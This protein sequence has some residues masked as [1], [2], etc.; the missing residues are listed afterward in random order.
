VSPASPAIGASNGVSYVHALGRHAERVLAP[1]SGI[2]SALVAL[3]KGKRAEDY[4]LEPVVPGI[5]RLHGRAPRIEEFGFAHPELRLEVAPPLRLLNDRAT[6]Y[7][8]SD[9]ARRDRGADGTGTLVGVADTGLDVTHPDMTDSAGLSR[10]AWMLDLYLPPVGEFPELEERFGIKDPMT[11]KVGQGAVL[12]RRMINSL[13]LDISKGRCVESATKRCAPTDHVGHGTHVTG[14]A[15]GRGAD[16]KFTGMAPAA[17]IVFVRVNRDT[18]QGIDNDDLVRAVQFMFDRAD[19]EKR[20]LVANV[21]LGGSFGPH[22]GTMLWEQAIAAHVGSQF[23][24]RAI[25]AAAGNEGS[26]LETPTHQSV[27]VTK[28]ARTR[29]PIRTRGAEAGSVQVWITMR[30]GAELD[31]GLDGPDG[32]WIAPVAQGRQNGRNT[33][34]YNAGVIFG[35]GFENSVIPETSRSAV[36]VW[37]GKWPTGDY[38]ITLEGSGMAELYVQGLGDASAGEQQAVFTHGVR[39]GTITLPATHPSIIAVGCSVSRPSWT[40]IGGAEIGLRV[41][42]LDPSGTLAVP[43]G[44]ELDSA[45]TLREVVDG[46]PCWFSSAGPTATGVPKPEITAPGAVIV[47]AMSRS[48]KP[49][50]PSSIFTNSGCPTTRTGKTDSRCM[51]VDERHGISVGTSMASPVVTG[52]VALLLQRDPTLTQDKIM[53]LLQGGV[54]RFRVAAPFDDQGGPGEV[55]A[56]GSLAALD[57]M[58]NPSEQLPSR[59]HSWVTTSAQYVAADGST[60]L[61]VV[62]ELRTADGARPADFFDHDRIAPVVLVDGVAVAPPPLVRRGPGVWFYAWR[63]PAG[64]GGSRASFGATFD[65]APIAELR[66]LPIA[67][68]VWTAFYPSQASG[69]S[70]AVTGSAPG[71]GPGLPAGEPLGALVVASALLRAFTRRRS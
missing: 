37:A 13:L 53:A 27:R 7:V 31:V 56:V 16:G 44:T 48:A 33:S 11:D 40:S 55:D 34:D 46:E 51:Q 12:N 45:P 58:Q 64:L 6:Q 35:S 63:P 1:G 60:P 36:V 2:M 28:G 30:E 5:A 67:A 9:V 24:G 4:G 23:P 20:P 26:I 17:D 42:I 21:S 38:H 59:E 65:G 18:G 3:P 8:R 52:V 39:E 32:E 19:A 54:H 43:R 29:V 70:C 66:S 50:A 61:T 14:T 15:A 68:D 10:V 57:L 22:D 71:R 41:P 25:V 47:S 62:V 69:S 49:G